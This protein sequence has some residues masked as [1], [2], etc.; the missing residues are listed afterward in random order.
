MW[1]RFSHYGLRVL[2]VLFMVQEL[3]FS[4]GKAFG[5]FAVYSAL[6][7]LSA[8]F[9]AYLAEKVLGLRRAVLLGG[10]IIGLGHL[11]LALDQ[12]YLGLAVV[13]AGSGLFMTNVLALMGSL[14]GKDAPGRESGFTLFYM[15]I[16][17]G[18]LLAT[19]LCATL[20]ETMGWKWGF[21][22]AAVGMLVANLALLRFQG[23]LGNV[24]RKPERPKMGI[25]SS[26]LPLIMLFALAALTFQEFALPLLP[27][28]TLAAMGFYSMK[29]WR[30]G[31]RALPL[32]LVALVLFFTAEEQ[33]GTSFI[34]YTERL[35]SG[36]LFGVPIATGSLLSVNPVIVIS[37]GVAAILLLRKMQSIGARLAL[38]FSLVALAF[39][40]LGLAGFVFA[41]GT[42]TLALPAAVIALISFA[43]LLIG[44]MSYSL[45][46]EVATRRKDPKIAALVPMGFS[47][48]ATLGGLTSKGI[49]LPGYPLGFCLIA[50]LLFI[51][52]G[53]LSLYAVEAPF[54]APGG[55][56]AAG[57]DEEP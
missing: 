47:L 30:Q 50:L 51:G 44:P 29:L 3:N 10:W 23:L 21:G 57:K 52:G 22:V 55:V 17:V 46:S 9:G 24:G 12:F 43:E 45:C 38:P 54:Q 41:P 35:G 37:C 27:W 33:L 2:L 26:G 15:G 31:E 56:G 32:A 6:V 28:A 13:I 49:A 40:L 4:D 39:L 42:M 18:A 1:H 11:F 7:E 14:Y 36:K 34:V 20:A 25:L 19:L 5:V 48:A 16:N 8:L 53:A